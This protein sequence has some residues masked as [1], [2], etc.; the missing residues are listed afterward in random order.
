M[1]THFIYFMLN[2]AGRNNTKYMWQGI[3]LHTGEG[4]VIIF[5]KI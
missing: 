5:T 4:I 2:I 3:K 1:D